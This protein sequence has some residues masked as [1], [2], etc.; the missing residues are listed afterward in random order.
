MYVPTLLLGVLLLVECAKKG[1][2]TG[3][4]KDTIPPVIVRSVPENYSINFT[5]NEIKIYFDEY[6]KLKE[7]Q[8]NLLISPPFK[9]QPTITPLSSSKVLKLKFNETLKENTTYVINFGQSI[10]DNNEDNPFDYFKYVFSTGNF[11]DSLKVSGTVNDALLPTIKDPVSVML[12]EVNT[13]FN[14]SIVYN[15]KPTYITVIKDSTNAF[16]ITNIKE[17]S[18]LLTAL[19]ENNSDYTF[20]PQNDKIGYYK[21]QITVPT[22]S[23]FDLSIFKEAQE[24]SLERPKQVS[25]NHIVFG[26]KGV[27]DEV[28]VKM[29]STKP[30]GYTYKVYK[31]AQ[32]DTLHYW[33]Q[34]E[35]P[36]D[37]TI[38]FKATYKKNI[39]T[40]AVRIKKLYKD[41]L[42]VNALKRRIL[43]L[44][45]SVA[46]R[47]NIPISK[48]DASKMLITDKDTLTIQ[49]NSILDERTNT[50]RIAF[51]KKEEQ[52]YK[53]QLFPGF[54]ED[55]YGN[56]NDT[57]N[58]DFAT[59]P[60]SD[61]GSI[62]LVIENNTME[63]TIVQIINEKFQVI[64]EQRLT[65]TDASRV[66]FK[67]LNPGN[68]YIRLIDDKN[69]NGK[70]DSG[71]YLRKQAPEKVI[72]Y[73]T[74]IDLRVNFSLQETFILK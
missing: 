34:P 9:T 67:E 8:K 6:I 20:Q 26:Y 14:D 4:A 66:S 21:N 13:S 3:G 62:D 18:Y 33:F 60:E 51:D 31:D 59:K 22:D 29:I 54:I 10:V 47:V 64:L 56:R 30:E 38:L 48:L 1:S 69:N 15:E 24:Y 70:W 63:N 74:K 2:P 65:V 11:I 7:I 41:S 12:Y 52:R 5:G 17:G 50:V 28:M 42:A 73:P 27:Q 45:D 49:G 71:N 61:Y 23:T 36:L 19:Q 25:K 39:D 58:L 16:E 72:Y 68:Y 37:S 44:S 55:F 57:I 46:L 43:T 35:L 53:V 40:L 32:K